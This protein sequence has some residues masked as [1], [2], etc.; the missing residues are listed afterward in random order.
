[1]YTVVNVTGCSD[2]I[3]KQPL[4]QATKILTFNYQGFETNK[5]FR[6]AVATVHVAPFGQEC[7]KQ[8]VENLLLP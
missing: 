1:M 2:I 3:P 6:A 5:T 4:K 8:Q 7:C